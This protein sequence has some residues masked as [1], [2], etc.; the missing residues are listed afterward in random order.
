MTA[1]RCDLEGCGGKHYGLGLCLKHYTRWKKHGDTEKVKRVVDRDGCTV[2]GCDRKHVAQGYCKRHY[3]GFK[4][5]GDPVYREPVSGPGS[6]HF[7][8]GRMV[9]PEGYVRVKV[10]EPDPMASMA[11]GTGCVPEHRLVMAR[12]IGRPLTTGETVHHI[13][14][15][16]GDNRL[17]NLQLRLG[18]HG[19]GAVFVCNSCGSRD[20]EARPL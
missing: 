16:R 12:A 19:S 15:V 6:A 20:I 5:Y 7:K 14:A 13:N 1:R 9:T 17:E 11:D 8:G 3:Y 2:D 18:H 4:R 10:Y